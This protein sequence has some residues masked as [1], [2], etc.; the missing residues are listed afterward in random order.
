LIF[1]SL[2][3]NTCMTSSFTKTEFCALNTNFTY[4]HVWVSMLFVSTIILF[5]FRIVPMMCY[6]FFI[7][8][9]IFCHF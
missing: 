8:L 2:V 4:M 1:Y 6:L 3:E 9:Y 5:D 7:S